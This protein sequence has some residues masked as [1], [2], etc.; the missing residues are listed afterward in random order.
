[1][2]PIYNLRRLATLIIIIFISGCAQVLY[3]DNVNLPVTDPAL[4]SRG[5]AYIS[6]T[7]SQPRQVV[8]TW[9]NDPSTTMTITWRTD[10]TEESHSLSYTDNPWLQP[11]QWT[12]V[13]AQS[14]TF[15][16]TK[17]WLHSV[18]LTNLTPGQTYHVTINHPTL[19]DQFS[20][21]TMPDENNRRDLV[22]LAGA[23]SRTQREVRREM[24]ELAAQLY[25]EFII[26]DGDF[27]A[28]ALSEQEWDE[29][30]DDWHELLITPDGRRVP[31]IPSIGNHEV[32]GSFL[33][34]REQAPFY[35]NR[36][37]VPEPKT[38]YTLKLAPDLVLVTL[39]SDHILEVTS[40]TD[41]LDSELT[42]HK[43]I[44]WKLV[45]YHVA[46][47]P[48]ARGF[49]EPVPT[50]IR[51][52][53]IPVLEMHNVDYVIE[54]HDHAF[55][56]TVPIRNNSRDDE[57]GIVYLGDGGWGA[58]LRDVKNPDDYW[59]LDKALKADHFWVFVL[60]ADGKTLDV[61]PL[62]RPADKSV[63]KVNS[64]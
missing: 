58:P 16:E 6:Y 33:Q 35:F 43:D 51:I 29:W 10:V 11:S 32:N 1:M 40:Q 19:A 46:A 48:S 22:F 18:E 12:T 39:D 37:V 4:Y 25:P 38:R 13:E 61:E 52:H 54:A 14:F 5:S 21:R 34:P 15:P 27:I 64:F 60:S 63:E 45:Q 59:W 26:F 3:E 47:W 9:Q 42:K 7:T 57:N 50:K 17:A 49:D 28:T 8:L 2:K 55:K 56:K 53:W 20:F 23:D 24:N 30:F 36:F 62:F 31:V 44:M 41:W